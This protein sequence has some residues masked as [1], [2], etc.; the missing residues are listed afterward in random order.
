MIVKVDD[1]RISRSKNIRKFFGK[2]NPRRKRVE[3][4]CVKLSC[5]KHR[6]EGFDYCAFHVDSRYQKGRSTHA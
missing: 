3:E 4:L 1:A 2:N 6:L 5:S